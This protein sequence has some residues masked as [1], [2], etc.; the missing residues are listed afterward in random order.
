MADTPAVWRTDSPRLLSLEVAPIGPNTV[1]TV[2]EYARDPR[3]ADQLTLNLANGPVTFHRLNDNQREAQVGYRY[4]A[5]IRLTDEQIAELHQRDERLSGLPTPGVHYEYDGRLLKGST[6]AKPL[7]LFSLR[8]TGQDAGELPALRMSAAQAYLAVGALAPDPMDVL[9]ITDRKVVGD[10]ARTWDPCDAASRAQNGVWTF[11]HLMRSLPGVT[12]AAG[13][14]KAWLE[15]WKTAQSVWPL[16]VNPRA[17]ETLLDECR[18][19]RHRYGR[20]GSGTVAVAGDRLST[21]SGD[22]MTFPRFGT[23]TPKRARRA[24]RFVFD[25]HRSAIRHRE[26]N[27]P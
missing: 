25:V 23:G 16:T 18:S 7:S 6:T 15:T 9:M 5:N 3:L 24:A 2:V 12:D 21:G 26:S 27:A 20:P 10:C 1:R 13:L 4:E 14:T 19:H 11:A 8:P 17:I 22:N